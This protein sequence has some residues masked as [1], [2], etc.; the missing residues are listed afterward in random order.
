M[1]TTFK[2]T[3]DGLKNEICVN[4][5][6]VG[7]VLRDMKNKWRIEPDFLFF[8]SK[9]TIKAKRFDSFY[10][11]GKYLADRYSETYFYFD[12]HDEDTQEIDMRGVFP[13]RG[14]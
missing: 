6:Y 12:D 5:K 1:K 11:A 14:P 13:Q 8:S 9:K 10:E 3:D 2:E 7:Y 4:D